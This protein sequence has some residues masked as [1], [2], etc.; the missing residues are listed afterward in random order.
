MCSNNVCRQATPILSTVLFYSLSVLFSYP[1]SLVSQPYTPHVHLKSSFASAIAYTFSLC[2]CYYPSSLS[3]VCRLSRSSSLA[4]LYADPTLTHTTHENICLLPLLY[5][6]I[7]LLLWC[8]ILCRGPNVKIAHLDSF[9]SDHLSHSVH[10]LG[11][12]RLEGLD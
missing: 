8:S 5:S 7:L 1:L 9:P 6:F 12:G 10:L 11:A 3:L 2:A 4:I